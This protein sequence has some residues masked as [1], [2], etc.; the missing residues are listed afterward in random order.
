M[1]NKQKRKVTRKFKFGAIATLFTALF[2]VAVILLNVIV[3]AVDSKVRLYVDLTADQI[4]SISDST[5]EAIRLQLDEA[6]EESGSETTITFTFLLPRDQLVATK[7]GSW[8]VTLAESYAEAFEE[9][10]VVFR[11]DL[12][13]HPEN[14][15]YYTDLGYTISSRSIIL[16]SSASKASFR[17]FNF[18]S[19]LV[20]DEEGSNVWAFKGE[21]QFNAAI[22]AV[23][24]QEIPVV[25]F[26]SGHGESTPESLVEIFYNCGF[27]VEYVDLATEEI[28]SATKLL[29]ISS[30]KK[31]IMAVEDDSVKSEYTKISD[32]LNDYRS[33]IVIASP[34]TPALPVLDELLEDWGIEIVRNQIIMDDS[35][36]VPGD[37]R[38]LYVNYTESENIANT[39]TSSLTELSNPPRTVSHFS[40]PIRI[41]DEG[42]GSIYGA[43]SVLETSD[44]SYVLVKDE[45]GKETKESGPFSVMAVSTRYTIRNN[46]DLYGHVV[47]FSSEAFTET[48]S[49]QSEFGNTDI[50]HSTIRLLTNENIPQEVNYK[51]LEDY[52]LTM[53]TGQIYTFGILSAVCAPCVIFALGIFVYIKRKN[54]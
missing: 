3:S 1:D 37:N 31:D 54:K 49:Y 51:V 20:Y 25:S 33:L 12:I 15:S 53:S 4:F 45:N 36:S 10:Q 17:I 26:T 34:S 29:V 38:R 6:K 19:C 43:E 44:N 16:S 9:I 7:E 48:N 46:T 47:V 21:M 8:V 52:T 22:I 28:S 50:I 39:I 11:D 23:T 2:I 40:A 5:K 41:L 35:Y 42:D 30:P 13:T 24:S 18:D 32:Y 27:A 14:Y